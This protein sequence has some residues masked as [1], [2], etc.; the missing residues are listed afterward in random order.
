MFLPRASSHGLVA[1]HAAEASRMTNA[2][3][4]FQ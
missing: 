2:L 1:I 3:Q 4:S